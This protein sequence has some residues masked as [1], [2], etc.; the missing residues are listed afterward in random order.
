MGTMSGIYKK[1]AVVLILVL[2]LFSG[3]V[4]VDKTS[5]DVNPSPGAQ[6]EITSIADSNIPEL[7]NSTTKNNEQNNPGAINTKAGTSPSV[8]TT[9]LPYSTPPAAVST[10]PDYSIPP[11]VIPTPLPATLYACNELDNVQKQIQFLQ[12][13]RLQKNQLLYMYQSLKSNATQNGDTQMAES[14]LVQIDDLNKMIGNIDNQIS[15]L[16][17]RESIL[18]RECYK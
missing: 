5:T 2:A 7:P 11:V 9:A 18:S 12:N 10:P 16:K 6:V 13:D 1:R 8:Q 14:Y 3:C 15:S 4:D 17:A